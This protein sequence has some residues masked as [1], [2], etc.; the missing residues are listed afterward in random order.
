METEALGNRGRRKKKVAINEGEAATVRRI[1][2]LYLSGHE[3]RTMGIK[4]IAKHLNERNHLMRGRPWRIQMVHKMLS[5]RSYLGE[6][7]FNVTEC[8]TRRKRPPSEWIKVTADPIVD[9]E[10]FERARQRREARAPATVPPRIVSSPTL[11]TASSSA[12]I[13]A[14]A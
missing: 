4:E 13:A 9:A 11:L 5:S 3:G 8:R 10:T 7:Y 6:H 12:G 2:E 1:Y 14:R